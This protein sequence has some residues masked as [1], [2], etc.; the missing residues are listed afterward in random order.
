MES[1]RGQTLREEHKWARTERGT[2][3][4]SWR[5][6]PPLARAVLVFLMTT[7]PSVQIRCLFQMNSQNNG[8]DYV[9]AQVV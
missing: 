7:Y 2:V 6:S 5:C 4:G 1:R 8:N 3:E 9:V